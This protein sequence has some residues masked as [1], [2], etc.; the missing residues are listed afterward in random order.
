M[1]ERLDKALLR[2]FTRISHSFQRLTGKT[3]FFLAKLA[4]MFAICVA[5][6]QVI[7]YW[8][9]IFGKPHGL[10][11]H[12][13]FV[14]LMIHYTVQC[15]QAE[16]S[17]LSGGRVLPGWV[18]ETRVFGRR[19]FWLVLA[20]IEVFLIMPLPIGEDRSV[21]LVYLTRS[22][23]C[24][25]A[26]FHYLISVDPLPPGTSKLQEWAKNIR[27]SFQKVSPAEG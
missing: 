21:F 24:N 16:D 3:N 5:L 18:F 22:I 13:I 4:A 25:L 6:M 14:M 17:I 11:F 27:A 20:L 1:L 8:V 19:R 26:V 2:V 23:A 10:F 9:P 7:N 12:L 15:D